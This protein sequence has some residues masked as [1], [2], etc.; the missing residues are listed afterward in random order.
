MTD[1]SPEIT[2]LVHARIMAKSGAERFLMG[3]RMH[4]A[5]RR[6]VISSLPAS[7]SPEE[8]RQHLRQRMYPDTPPESPVPRQVSTT[9][10]KEIEQSGQDEA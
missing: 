4:E 3:V 7:A 6:M 5:A 8:L 9:I 2:A 10:I 1:T